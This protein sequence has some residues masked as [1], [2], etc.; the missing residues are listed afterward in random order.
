LREAENAEKGNP[1]SSTE[2]ERTPGFLLQNQKGGTN[3]EQKTEKGKGGTETMES[4]EKSTLS[5]LDEVENFR[6]IAASELFSLNTLIDLGFRASESC[7]ST[8]IQKRIESVVGSIFLDW[9]GLFCLMEKAATEAN[10]ALEKIDELISEA[11]APERIKERP[12]ATSEK[13]ET[14]REIVQAKRKEEDRRVLGYKIKQQ[15]GAISD[16]ARDIKTVLNAADCSVQ[17]GVAAKDINWVNLFDLLK[18]KHEALV[19]E[20]GGLIVLAAYFQEEQ[21]DAD[22]DHRRQTL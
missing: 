11:P 4:R 17:A 10:E 19:D 6:N 9:Q 8:D 15:V 22:C 1:G 2:S 14:A 5:L 21:E 7:T 13:P 16:K 20:L 12:H 3:M 18:E